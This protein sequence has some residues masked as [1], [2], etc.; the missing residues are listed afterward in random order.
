MQGS[1]WRGARGPLAFPR[2]PCRRRIKRRNL[3]WSER[4]QMAALIGIAADLR[5]ILAAHVTF[6]FVDRRC[7]RSANNVERHGLMGVTAEATDLKVEISGVQ[8]VAEARRRLSRSF[9]SEHTLVP[10]D[11]RQTVSFLPSLG[12]AFRRMPDRTSVNAL[13]R[14]G[15]HPAKMRQLRFDRQAATDWACSAW[16]Y[17]P[18][19]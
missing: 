18:R 5:A 14:L 11:T 2:P 1:N 8:G 9:E 13:S 12:R 19:W 17:N 15:A 4:Y 16:A 6:Q 10:G 7:L 3:G